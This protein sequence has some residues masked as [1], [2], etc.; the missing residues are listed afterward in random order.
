MKRLT[1][2]S[3]KCT[4]FPERGTALGSDARHGVIPFGKGSTSTF[5]ITDNYYAHLATATT[6]FNTTTNKITTSLN[7]VVAKGPN[8][9]FGVW[10]G[11]HYRNFYGYTPEEAETLFNTLNSMSDE[12]LDKFIFTERHYDS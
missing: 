9:R 6:C 5:G 10:E 7:I 1:K 12:E 4:A 11:N 8:L 3:I 2:T